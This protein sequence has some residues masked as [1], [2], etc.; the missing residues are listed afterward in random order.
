MKLVVGSPVAVTSP[1]TCPG[2]AGGW[3]R[4]AATCATGVV[5]TSSE[6]AV[7]L[8]VE[9]LPPFNSDVLT[10]VCPTPTSAVDLYSFAL[11]LLMT[12]TTSGVRTR[13]ASSRYFQRQTT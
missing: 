7:T 12:I 10:V 11:E 9:K 3:R 4:P 1:A 5:V 8:V 6:I 2:F 13:N